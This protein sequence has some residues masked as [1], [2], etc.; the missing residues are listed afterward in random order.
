MFS[1]VLTA[2][3]DN[4]QAVVQVKDASGA[5]GVWAGAEFH[6]RS[7]AAVTAAFLSGV[8][9]DPSAASPDTAQ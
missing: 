6:Q 3:G 9:T 2:G 1:G 7:S 8:L 4:T 5:A